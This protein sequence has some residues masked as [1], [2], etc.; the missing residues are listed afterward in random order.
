MINQKMNELSATPMGAMVKM[1]GITASSLK[2]FLKPF[3][4]AIS[5]KAGLV[6]CVFRELSSQSSA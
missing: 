1:A 3:I 2:P 5:T 4:K 6:Q